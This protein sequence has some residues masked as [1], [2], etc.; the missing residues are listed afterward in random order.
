MAPDAPSAL[1]YLGPP[2]PLEATWAVLAEPLHRWFQQAF[3]DPTPAQRLAWPALAA[4]QNLLL[5]APTGSGKTLA[6]FVPI[7]D[8][9]LAEAAPATLRCLYVAPL[10]ALGND[11]CQNLRRYLDEIEPFRPAGGAPL[12]VGLRT[13]DTSARARR[14]LE[15]EPPDLL[16][17]TPESLALLLSRP[18]AAALF[19]GLRWVVVDEVHA[20][21][22]TKRGA[23]LALSLERLAALAGGRL[24]RVGL[25][26]TCAPVTEAAHFLVGTGRPCAVALV[27]ET[28]P[29][30]LRIEPLEEERESAERGAQ[31][32]EDCAP[33]SHGFLARLLDRL[34]PELA[35]NRTTLIF[36]NVRSLAE[37]LAWALRRRFP[38]WAEQVAVHHSALAAPR[39]RDVERRFKTGRLRAVVSSTSLELGIDIGTVDA[40]VLVHP[41]GGVVRLWQ[42]VGRGGHAPGR[43]RRGLVLTATPAELLEAAVTGAAGHSAQYEPLRVP[44]HP[45]DV[46]CQQLLGLAAQR[47]WTAAAA[48]AL[49]RRAYPYRDLPRPDFDDCLDYLSGRHR[50]GRPWL[51]ARLRWEGNVFTLCD[52]RT[53]RLVRR[54]LGTIIADEP[55][56][57]L[58]RRLQIADCRLHIEGGQSAI[59]NLQSAIPVGH[60]DDPFADRLRPGDRF[61]L[62]GRCL[63]YRG[64][65]GRALLVDEVAGRPL[66]PRWGGEGWPL[67]ADLA[68]RLYLF[69]DRAAE[70]LRDGPAAL[71]G[72][73]RRE[74]G[75]GGKAVAALVAYFQRQECVSE[76]PDPTTC[77]VEVVAGAAGTDYYVHTPLSRA[78]ND[79][80]ARVAVLRLV[81]DRGRA[82]A[83]MVADLGLLLSVAGSVE[84][85]PAELRGLLGARDFEADLDRALAESD[86][87]RERFR[88]AA[89]TGLMLLRNPLGRRRL[90]GGRDWAERRLFHQVCAADPD[91]VLLRQAHREVCQEV[92]DAGAARAFVEDLPR[93]TLRCRRLGRASPFAEGWTQA[94]PG[95]AEAV[96][97][98][99]EALRRL[100]A[101]LWNDKVT[102]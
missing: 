46:L 80:L 48:F 71:A 65:S 56:P 47:P 70:A 45:L 27:D 55:R 63:E 72:L 28:A 100:H 6:A 58:L 15:L 43:P 32:A 22:A 95:P 9:L 67:S 20:L 60:V 73:L 1:D 77:L 31:N 33:R 93:C 51:P 40:V 13:G 78:G 42:R 88:R 41:P 99:E 21:A 25:S 18:A 74:Y 54:N 4:G 57:V 12:R 35:A 53:A 83:A 44:A 26:A 2:P 68:R 66:V 8:R 101:A 94:G 86:T 85:T 49:V 76:I 84:L 24:Q 81:R 11:A 37:R 3:G 90:V 39:R 38:G 52:G 97:S 82:S 7:L 29:L 14:Q 34:E 61:L 10:K 69:R 62:D 79:A 59:C 17:T 91:F 87:L 19:C 75:L 23:D 64:T 89:L 96:E 30:E 36:T 102:T 92:V 98:P 50:D 16:V 5:S